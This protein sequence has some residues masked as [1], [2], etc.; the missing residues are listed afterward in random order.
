MKKPT[1]KEQLEGWLVFN[2]YWFWHPDS[3]PCGSVI[4]AIIAIAVV[5]AWGMWQ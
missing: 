3:G 5:L 2:G 1:L 4:M